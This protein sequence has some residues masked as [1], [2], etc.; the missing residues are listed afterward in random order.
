MT[1]DSSYAD[2]RA[3]RRNTFLQEARAAAEEESLPS[4]VVSRERMTELLSA[5]GISLESN[6]A[7]RALDGSSFSGD[8]FYHVPGDGNRYLIAPGE[9]TVYAER[10]VQASAQRSDWGDEVAA[11]YDRLT[12]R[13]PSPAASGAP[14]HPVPKAHAS[15]SQDLGDLVVIEFEKQRAAGLRW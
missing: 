12:G 11:E 10:A 7:R 8:D 4:V 15:A 1:T 9:R 3:R 5:A 2:R 14:E 6:Y 13:A